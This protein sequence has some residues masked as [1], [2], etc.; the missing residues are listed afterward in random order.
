M[1]NLH[2][3]ALASR[4]FQKPVITPNHYIK[5]SLNIRSSIF[6]TASSFSKRSYYEGENRLLPLLSL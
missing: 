4:L 6:E 3:K 5:A 2:P 1:K